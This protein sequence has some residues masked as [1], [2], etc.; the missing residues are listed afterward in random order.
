[1]ELLGHAIWVWIALALT[2]V[3]P[4]WVV[5]R[6]LTL[7]GSFWWIALNAFALGCA[8]QGLF[9]LFWDRIV[10]SHPMGELL[11]YV[12]FWAVASWGALRFSRTREVEIPMSRAESWLLGMIVLAAVCIRT[13]HPLATS[14]LGQ[15]DAYSHL[16]FIRQVLADG[17]IHNQIYPPAYSWIMALPA[18]TLRVD[19]Y[20]LARFGGA[21]WGAGLTLS[22]Y[23]LGRRIGRQGA[24]L[25]TAAL[26]AFC[27]LWMPLLKTGVGAFANQ[28]GLF[29][30]PLI[31][32]FYLQCR[33]GKGL[34]MLL[35]MSLALVSAVP[36]MW[37]SLMPVLWM[38]HLVAGLSRESN[39]WKTTGRLML[40]ILPAIVLLSWQ[41]ARIQG[42]HSTA[43]V[44]IVT[45]GA[46]PANSQ[47][48]SAPVESE[49]VV[50]ISRER[51]LLQNYF[52]IKRR[53]Y[54][55]HL[56]NGAGL[57]L[58]LIFIFA[59]VAGGRRK[60]PELRLLGI[61]GLIT[62]V[63]AATGFMQFSGYQREG[64]SLLLA[65]A[66]L[67]GTMLA[68][69]MSRS[70]HRSILKPVVGVGFVF[71][72]L[73]ACRRPPGHRP[74]FSAAED[75]IVRTAREMSRR[76]RENHDER[77]LTVVTRA[78]TEFQGNQGDLVAAVIGPSS[79]VK[80]LTVSGG[81]V[82]EEI[83]KSERQYLFLMDQ[84]SLSAQWSPGLFAQVQ[85]EQV[86]QYRA[87]HNRLFKINEQMEQQ[88]E[89]L[90]PSQWKMKS[91]SE[92]PLLSAILLQPRESQ[93]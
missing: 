85:P 9:G 42:N 72:F 48:A 36:I 25:F 21:V 39:G 60:N 73:W 3:L 14:A 40:A 11:L 2:L 44:A 22:M 89:G 84:V 31:L 64:W 26:V 53:G 75:E 8:S 33:E 77:P 20:D 83:L 59:V 29:L 80:T 76:V 86:E 78:F 41:A 69:I 58:G 62:S 24:G 18:L 12:G 57:V 46:A 55:S 51:I 7:A 91:I 19:P 50:E 70:G 65:T 87:V 63:Q 35:L 71:L 88:L 66:C 61:W 10:L 1:M 13:L 74:A 81:Q 52:S 92:S 90:S 56:L 23:A 30:L 47:T 82:W 54:A 28:S 27:P 68:W 43:T 93:P 32:L 17:M 15:S 16:Q 67:C 34:W 37:I 38:D 49:S 79:R 45:G 5:A 6:R 4:P